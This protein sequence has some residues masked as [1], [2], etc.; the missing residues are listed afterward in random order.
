M[1]EEGME[2]EVETS[3]PEVL[4]ESVMDITMALQEVLKVALIHDG[5]VRGLRECAKALDR[6]QAQLCILA[7]DCDEPAYTRLVEALCA[8]RGIN[9]VKVPEK[10]QLG[11]W[12]GLAKID[13]TGTATKVVK[14]SCVVVKDFGDTSKGLEFLLNYLKGE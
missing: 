12:A 11:Q 5:L 10:M 7:S 14:A 4:D 2:V 13:E 9:L 1:A 6:R 3:V 8:E